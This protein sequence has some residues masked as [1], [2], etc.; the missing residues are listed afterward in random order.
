MTKMINN[1]EKDLL[2]KKIIFNNLLKETKAYI[3][4][5]VYNLIKTDIEKKQKPVNE[6]KKKI[7]YKNIIILI[8]Y[9]IQFLSIIYRFLVKLKTIFPLLKLLLIY[10]VKLKM[11]SQFSK[12]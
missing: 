5:E 6:I 3:K 9:T 4:R 2:I 12:I 10:S 7:I 1:I 11:N 8:S